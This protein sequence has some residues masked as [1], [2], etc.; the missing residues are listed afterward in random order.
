MVHKKVHCGEVGVSRS[1]NGKYILLDARDYEEG[2][3]ADVRI[4]LTQQQTFE[5]IERLYRE[6]SCLRIDED[7]FKELSSKANLSISETLEL[8]YLR[9]LIGIKNSMVVSPRRSDSFPSPQKCNKCDKFTN[10]FMLDG[11][12]FCEQCGTLLFIGED[13]K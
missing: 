11:H 4:V 2:Y 6:L 3:N 12:A 10:C 9:N 8:T 7:R 1:V 13:G 5:V